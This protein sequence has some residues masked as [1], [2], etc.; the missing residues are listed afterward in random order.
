MLRYIVGNVFEPVFSQIT[1]KDCALRIIGGGASQCV[2]VK[3]GT[4]NVTYSRKRN[5]EYTL[6]R[7]HISEV[8]EGDDVPV[9]VSFTFVW[10]YIMAESSTAACTIEEALTQTG[11]ADDWTSSD[12][13]TCRP[14]AVDLEITYAPPCSTGLSEEIITL[15]DFRWEELS[16]DLNAGQISVTGKCNISAP[17]VSRVSSSTG[18]LDA[19]ECNVPA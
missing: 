4:G 16:H 11:N 10:D 9:D 17:S 8:R 5:V 13:D 2:F 15:G 19:T 12:S 1:L 7:G 14:Y 18:A 3:I 6:D